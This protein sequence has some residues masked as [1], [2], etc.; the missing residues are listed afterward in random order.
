MNDIPEIFADH[1]A[2]FTPQELEQLRQLLTSPVYLKLLS[3]AECM[4][5][6]ANCMGA[7]SGQR[8]AFSND[9]ANARLAEIRGWDMHK[10]ALFAALNPKPKRQNL[11]ESFQPAEVLPANQKE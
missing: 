7:G 11:E 5:P 10:S 9:R 1:L 6:S 3:I 8:D 4:R 2:A